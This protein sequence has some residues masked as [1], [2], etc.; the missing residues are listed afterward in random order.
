MTIETVTMAA[1]RRTIVVVSI[2]SVTT[3]AS[4]SNDGGSKN[5]PQNTDIIQ[6]VSE[7]LAEI[8]FQIRFQM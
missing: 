8:P 5:R 6:Q 7:R 2:L 4:G 1:S 3:P